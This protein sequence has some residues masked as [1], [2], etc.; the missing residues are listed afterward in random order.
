MM[1]TNFLRSSVRAAGAIAF[2]IMTGGTAAEAQTPP[3][4]APRAAPNTTPDPKILVI[5]RNAILRASKAGSVAWKSA[6]PA[7]NELHR[8]SVGRWE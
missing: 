2:M 8:S 3:P 5:D 6:P 4:A 1:N 7:V